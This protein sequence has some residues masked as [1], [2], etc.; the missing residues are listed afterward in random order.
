MLKSLALVVTSVALATFGDAYAQTDT[1]AAPPN[2]A[3]IAQIQSL[4]NLLD[5]FDRPDVDHA[6]L[7]RDVQRLAGLIDAE[8]AE[9]VE[10]NCIAL[11]TQMAEVLGGTLPR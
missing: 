6:L 1:A 9:A 5:Q 4:E 11:F 8:L 3:Q 10:N 7:A 2:D